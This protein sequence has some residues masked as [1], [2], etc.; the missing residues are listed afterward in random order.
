MLHDCIATKWLK[1]GSVVSCQIRLWLTIVSVYK[2]YLLTIFTKCL[3]GSYNA[4]RIQVQI[5]KGKNTEDELIYG[6]GVCWA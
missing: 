3:N 4:H 5:R 6:L 1:L 2:L